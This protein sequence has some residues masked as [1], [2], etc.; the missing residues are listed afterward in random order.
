MIIGLKHASTARSQSRSG[1][2][3]PAFAS[4]MMALAIASR[5]VVNAPV[6][7]GLDSELECE[8]QE[9]RRLGIEPLTIKILSDWHLAVLPGSRLGL[10]ATRK[11]IG[12]S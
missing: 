3:S 8:A 11:R 1:S 5:W 4:L 9:T 10:Y 2:R 12:H 6:M 7:Q